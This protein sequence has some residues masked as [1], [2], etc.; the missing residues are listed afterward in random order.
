M[1]PRKNAPSVD[2]EALRLACVDFIRRRH[3]SARVVHEL[4]LSQGGC[5]IDVAAVSE[6]R[7]VM[8]EIKSRR[9]TLKR[10]PAQMKAARD[11]T[12]D[13]W[14]V[15]DEKHVAEIRNGSYHGIG[16]ATLFN[17]ALQVLHEPDLDR[18]QA[19]P[20]AVADMLWREE[21]AAVFG[22]PARAT[23]GLMAR[24]AV[25]RWGLMEIT[26]RVCMAIRS[27]PFPRADCVVPIDAS[28]LKV[29]LI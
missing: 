12:S 9:D 13:L 17:G 3:Q 14:M 1:E 6:S 4:Q 24:G 19:D 22:G 20:R 10:L 21:M 25:D 18:R 27:R 23:R 28:K 11:V 16:L 15:V 26:R 8:F 7:M 5:R 29:G 2:E